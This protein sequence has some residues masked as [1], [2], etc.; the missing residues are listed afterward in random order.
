M[1]FLPSRLRLDRPLCPLEALGDVSTLARRKI[2]IAIRGGV[3]KRRS[4]RRDAWNLSAP[5]HVTLGGAARRTEEV[6]HA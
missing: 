4:C 2:P 1:A 5:A 3:G 6:C